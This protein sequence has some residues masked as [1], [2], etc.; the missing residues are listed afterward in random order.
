M[1]GK[2]AA[3][4]EINLVGVELENLLLVKTVLEFDS[5]NGFRQLTAPS[6]LGGKKEAARKLHG[7]GAGALGDAFAPEIRP[8]RAKHAQ[9]IETGML[10]K[11][12]ILGGENGIQEHFGDIVKADPAAFLAG[13]VKE[14]GQ[15]LRLDFGALDDVAV[16]EQLDAAHAA[17]GEIDM[18]RVLAFEKGIAKRVHFDDIA[19]DA[20]PAGRAIYFRFVVAIVL[21]LADQLSRCEYLA[22]ENAIGRAIYAGAGLEHPSREPLVDHV[23]KGEPGVGENAGDDQHQAEETG[24]ERQAKARE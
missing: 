11:A 9:E 3:I 1:N 10:E 18:Q 4:A 24:E 16:I 7:E 15:Q 23:A 14:I 2:A 8:H 13:S 20:V 17:A 6:T 12:L 22:I 5:H 19:V 21:Q